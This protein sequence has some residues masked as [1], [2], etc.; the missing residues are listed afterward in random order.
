MLSLQVVH[1]QCFF[2]S[3]YVYPSFIE[4][5]L[6]YIVAKRLAYTEQYKLYYLLPHDISKIMSRGLLLSH[7]FRCNVNYCVIW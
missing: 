7:S 6:T 4:L 3:V 2:S 5:V 1:V